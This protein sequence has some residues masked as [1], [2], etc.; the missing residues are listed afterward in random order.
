MN[1]QMLA[2]NE[3]AKHNNQIK[4]KWRCAPLALLKALCF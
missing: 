1:K 3:Y 4:A 2:N